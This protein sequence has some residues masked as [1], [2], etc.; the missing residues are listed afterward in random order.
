MFSME[1]ELTK[2]KRATMTN[3]ASIRGL[4]ND[5][6][7]VSRIRESVERHGHHFLS[8]LFSQKEQDY[9]YKFKDA[10]P[11]FA[12]RFA[13]KEAIAK[14]LGTGFGK[15]LAWHDVEILS[16]DFGK[17]TVHFSSEAQKKFNQP[18]ILVS[19]SH[20]THYAN[21]VAVWC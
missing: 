13:A 15:D 21:A 6:I 11:H 19:I 17:P 14:A 4:G 18:N 12:G 5:I 7:E 1:K 3:D 20:C 8:R 16:D 10:I 9:C 2:R